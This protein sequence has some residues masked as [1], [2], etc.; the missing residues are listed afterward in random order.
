MIPRSSVLDRL[1]D[2]KSGKVLDLD[3]GVD[4]WAALI[5]KS[6]EKHPVNLEDPAT[7]EL[8][9]VGTREACTGLYACGV[10][11]AVFTPIDTAAPD[12]EDP[13][14][15]WLTMRRVALYSADLCSRRKFLVDMWKWQTL[16]GGN[17]ALRNSWL[18]ESRF[19]YTTSDANG[20]TDT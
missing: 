3:W 17:R 13:Y 14:I 6:D 12:F 18:R 16:R 9:D 19:A 15:R 5:L 11:D 7:F 4:Q 8:R 2:P 20:Y 10:H 1:K